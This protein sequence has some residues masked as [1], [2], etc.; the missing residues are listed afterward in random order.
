MTQK[1]AN[2]WTKECKVQNIDQGTWKC[3]DNQSRVVGARE[4]NRWKLSQALQKVISV[5]R[6]I[7]NILSV[8]FFPFLLS[9]WRLGLVFEHK[10]ARFP[11]SSSSLGALDPFWHKHTHTSARDLWFRFFMVFGFLFPFL[12]FSSSLIVLPIVR[13]VVWTV[14]A[15]RVRVG[16]LDRDASLEYRGHVARQGFGPF[17]FPLLLLD[18]P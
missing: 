15:T 5:N 17:H 3:D 9:T 4:A 7:A 16:H 13:V 1:K 18:F 8:F 10:P 2:P 6:P 14:L 12:F 11:P